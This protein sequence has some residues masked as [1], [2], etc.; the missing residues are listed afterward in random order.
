MIRNTALLTLMVFTFTLFTPILMQ[1]KEAEA[2]KLDEILL[3]KAVE[4]TIQGVKATYAYVRNKITAHKTGDEH[5]DNH[6]TEEDGMQCAGSNCTT[7]VTSDDHHAKLCTAC[8]SIYFTC[9][10]H[11]CDNNSSTNNSSSGY[12]DYSWW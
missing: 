3:G 10:S 9:E 4:L 8:K 12:Y 6:P 7:Q 1:P 5:P 2:D 11:T